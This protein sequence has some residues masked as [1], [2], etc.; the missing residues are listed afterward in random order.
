[1]AKRRHE[2]DDGRA[3]VAPVVD[4]VEWKVEVVA[5]LADDENAAKGLVEQTMRALAEDLALEAGKGLRRAEAAARA[6]DEQDS[7]YFVPTAY[8]ARA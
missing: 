7:G 8:H 1:M 5:G 4:D 6:S 3:Q 2:A